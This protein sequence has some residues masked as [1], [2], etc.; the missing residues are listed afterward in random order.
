MK[1]VMVRE[2]APS[3]IAIE[4]V[5]DPRPGQGE[6]V[7]DVVAADTNFPDAL[8]VDGKYQV[9]PPLPFSPGKAA[10][11]RIAAIG[12]DVHGFKIGDAVAAYVEYGAYAE[13]VIASADACFPIPSGIAFDKVAALSI[14][15]Q[16]AWFALKERAC[17]H[18]GETVLVLGASGG[19]GMASVQLAKAL[20]AGKVIAGAR[21]ESNSQIAR[22]AGADDI[23]DLGNPDLRDTLRDQVFALTDGR[24]ADVV[25]DPVGGDANAAALR[26][27]AWCG[28]LVV[29]GFASGQIPVV[30]T[31]YLLLKNIAVSGLQ[32]S[33][34][35]TRAPEKIA[36]AQQEIF[37]LYKRG[38][39]DPII[40]RKLP[41]EDF[42]IAL[43]CYRHGQSQG[44]IILEVRPS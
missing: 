15:Y 26:A 16:T 31:N 7:I 21:G 23:I 6:V 20:G 29:V 39:I 30:K 43:D 38:L 11:G 41:L 44:K 3:N 1:A 34:Y 33:D 36:Q 13:K 25:I 27:L 8:V 28:R 14:V 9:K 12:S 4:D 5:A 42:A 40:S 24:G 2:F 32:W 22:K 19:I 37:D 18:S 35:R 10:A 17:L